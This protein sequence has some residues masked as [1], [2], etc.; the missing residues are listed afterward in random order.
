M[1]AS[2]STYTDSTLDPSLCLFL[3]CLLELEKETQVYTEVT[4]VM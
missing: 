1:Q 4:P 3:L 2:Q